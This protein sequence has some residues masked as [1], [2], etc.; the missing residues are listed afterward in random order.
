MPK[1]K[2]DLGGIEVEIFFDYQ[3]AEQLT[4]DYP[5][6]PES[7]QISEVKID[8]YEDEEV[9]DIVWMERDKWEED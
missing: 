2:T 3:P 8:S 6:C 7:I 4:R 1:L 9:E 5:G